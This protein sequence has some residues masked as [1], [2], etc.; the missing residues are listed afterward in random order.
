MTLLII[1]FFLFFLITLTLA[2]FLYELKRTDTELKVI[3]VF[4]GK[5]IC[6]EEAKMY[7][8]Y[9]TEVVNGIIIK[10]YLIKY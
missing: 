7:E 10:Y 6:E 3:H 2:I 4:N 8:N 9:Y 1:I 5:I